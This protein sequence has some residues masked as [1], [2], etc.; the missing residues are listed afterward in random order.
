MLVDVAES[1]VEIEERT[2]LRELHG[3]HQ[4]M[5]L[6]EEK[7][8]IECSGEDRHHNIRKD[9]EK[10]WVKGNYEKQR[11][12]KIIQKKRNLDLFLGKRRISGRER[13]QYKAGEMQ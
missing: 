11:Q 12:G 9:V 13:R 4:V 7:G 6:L 8:E 3:I 2:L 5:W 10:T 1:K